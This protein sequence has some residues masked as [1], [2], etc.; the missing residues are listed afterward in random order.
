MKKKNIKYA[1]KWVY[2]QNDDK[3][4]QHL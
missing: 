4:K 3:P 2:G 1:I